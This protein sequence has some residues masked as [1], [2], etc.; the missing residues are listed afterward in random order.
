MVKTYHSKEFGINLLDG[1]WENRF[2]RPRTDDGRSRADISSAVQ[3]QKAEL[4]TS[5]ILQQI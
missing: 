2:N 4:K 3:Y 1:F 5:G